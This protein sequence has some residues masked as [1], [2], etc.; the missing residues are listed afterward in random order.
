MKNPIPRRRVLKL[1]GT[2]AAVSLVDH[3]WLLASDQEIRIGGRAAQVQISHISPYTVRI[4]LVESAPAAGLQAPND[5][6]LNPALSAAV[7]AGT[8]KSREQLRVEVSPT[9][10][11]ITISSADGRQ[12]QRLAID[13]QTGAVTFPL[14]GKPVLGMGEGG[15]QFDRRGNVDPMRSG[16]G[17]YRLRTFGGRVPIQWLVGTAGWAMFVH[18]PLGA[19]DLTGESGVFKPAT[20]DAALHLDAFVVDASDPARAMGEYARI[21]GQPEMPPLWSLG[22]QQSHRTIASRDEIIGV[23]KTFREK[24][25]PCDAVIYLGTGFCPSGWNTENGSFQF[26]PRVFT[27]PK[28]ILDEF[29]AMHFRVILHSVILT[30]TLRGTVRDACPVDRFDA[31]QAACLW[32]AHR[33]NFALGVD[34]WWP[35]EGDPLDATARL[36]R[37]RMHY[38]GPQLDRPNER[39][40]ALHRNGYAGMQ[41]Y[42]PFLWSGD[43]YSTWETLKN[44][45][46]IGINIGLSGVPLWGTDTGGFVPTKDFNGELF[47][48]WFQFSSFCP[49]FRSHGR[50]WKLRLPWQWNTGELGPNEVANYGEAQNPDPSE[51]HNPDVEP[52]CKKYLEL[53]YRLLP[54]LYSAVR[55]NHETGLPI[56]RAL[57]LHYPDDAAAAARGDE[58]LWGRDMLVAPVTEKG[59]TSRSVYL[60]RGDWY[61]FWTEERQQGGREISRAVDLATTPL[62]VRAGSIIPFGP[63]KQHTGEQSEEPVTFVVYPGAD[64]TFSMYEDD[65]ISF[66][67]RHGTWSRTE[68][69]WNDAAKKLSL[70]GSTGTKAPYKK[71]RLQIR[72][73]GDNATKTI[74]FSGH[75]QD[76]QL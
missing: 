64:G 74:E 59:A 60:P 49:L 11:V 42:A 62:F 65:G 19:F 40:Y 23:A 34:G 56:I 15:P 66:G 73:A 27:E 54:Y 33:K 25:L 2:T 47:V 76:V 38:E 18:Q 8:T 31:E 14:G 71:R 68:V 32:D 51:L 13:D 63:V 67:Y 57:W 58:Y 41:R 5:G 48:R 61:D 26:N 4:R 70:R 75:S 30:R 20:P 3:S 35:D 50:T 36:T 43:V 9:L 44:H 21:T 24:K 10:P 52:I 37:I 6:A 69:K 28:A 46:P 16:Q 17:G 12:L 1:L 55:E 7:P 53:R 39:P 72:L 22:Y 45:V 29:H